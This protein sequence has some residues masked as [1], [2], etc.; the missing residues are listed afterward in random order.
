MILS[1]KI[2]KTQSNV[3]LYKYTLRWSLVKLLIPVYYQVQ[4]FWNFF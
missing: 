2:A 1:L 3:H 4:Y